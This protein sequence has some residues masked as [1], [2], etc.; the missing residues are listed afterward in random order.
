MIKLCVCVNYLN[1]RNL[2]GN[3]NNIKTSIKQKKINN[4]I[5]GKKLKEILKT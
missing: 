5:C 3:N 4:A 1:E 2:L